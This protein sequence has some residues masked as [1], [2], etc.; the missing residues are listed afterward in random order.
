V[1]IRASAESLR[2]LAKRYG[3]NPKTVAKWKKRSSS[4]DLPR[5]SKAGRHRKLTAEEE[6]I[7]VQFREHTLLP[8]DD[9]LYALQSQIPH[10][11]RSTLHRCLQRH[12]ISRLVEACDS[13]PSAEKAAPSLGNLHIDRSRVSST[14]GTHYLFNAIEQ[15]SKFVFV[16]LASGGTAG[17]AARFLTE[18]AERAPFRIERVFTVGAEPFIENGDESDFGRACG[19]QEIEQRLTPAADPWTRSR[20]ARI[21]RMLEDSVTFTSEAYLVDLLGDFVHAYNFRRRL[22]SLRGKTPYEFLCQAWSEK[23]QAFLRHPHHDLMGL[24]FTRG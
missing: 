2:A 6:S 11:R 15:V 20:G 12:G 9:C 14:E 24:E 23:P 8:V 18:L 3:I 4:E 17:D 13:E 21:G 22:K 10:L 19:E 7:V 1:A 5:G 16:R